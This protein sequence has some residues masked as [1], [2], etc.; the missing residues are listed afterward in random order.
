MKQDYTK[1]GK[2]LWKL[3]ILQLALIGRKSTSGSKAKEHIEPWFLSLAKH[4]S[5]QET[6]AIVSDADSTSSLDSRLH[7]TLRVFALE[8]LTK[9]CQRG[10]SQWFPIYR[11]RKRQSALVASCEIMCKRHIEQLRSRA[12]WWQETEW[13][14]D[15]VTF[16][17]V[18]IDKA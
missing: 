8:K 16:Q 13:S 14:G 15:P 11:I 3:R 12:W 18:C 4:Q 5:E 1:L 17:I 9:K 6:Q 10:G 2:S 7:S